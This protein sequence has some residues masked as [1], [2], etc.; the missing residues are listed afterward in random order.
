MRD[1]TWRVVSRIN[2]YVLLGEKIP[3]INILANG[4]INHKGMKLVRLVLQLPSPYQPSVFSVL[5][6]E[7]V[8]K[9]MQKYKKA[10][11]FNRLC[12]VFQIPGVCCNRSTVQV[13]CQL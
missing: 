12:T 13:E 11:I 7:A 9:Y 3:R 4:E 6:L 2:I 10:I 5:T 1:F 8:K